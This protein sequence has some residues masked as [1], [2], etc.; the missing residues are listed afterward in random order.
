MAKVDPLQ[1]LDPV[2]RVVIEL[3]RGGFIKRRADGTIDFV[4]PVP[5]PYNYGCIPAILA[6]DGA[7]LDALV[8]GPRLAAGT[9]LMVPVR[10]AVLFVDCGIAD[11]KV[12]CSTEALTAADRRGVERFF[13]AYTWFKRGLARARRQ[14]GATSFDG[15]LGWGESG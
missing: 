1:R 3:P 12:V 6:D 11:P 8:L 10:D 13:T 15:W 2:P 4:S 5:C 9:A 7:P 14:T